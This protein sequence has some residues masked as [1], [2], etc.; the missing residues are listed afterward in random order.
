MTPERLEEK[1]A[2]WYQGGVYKRSVTESELDELIVAM[3]E[4]WADNRDLS[5]G[6]DGMIADREYFEK[7]AEKAE[8][9]AEH[10]NTKWK[11]SEAEVERHF[12]QIQDLCNT[13]L[14]LRERAEQAEAELSEVDEGI[15]D[16]TGSDT[17]AEDFGT[18][19]H[20]I[21]LIGQSYDEQN[22][23]AEKAEAA[24]EHWNTKWKEAEADRDRWM[25]QFDEAEHR[26][27]AYME[28]RD[29]L[30]AKL[31]EY[32]AFNEPLRRTYN[33]NTAEEA[34]P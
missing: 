22:A 16:A 7:I 21:E 19:R 8:A 9:A 14:I 33:E 27:L 12:R 28:E 18:R 17:I 3:E 1:M 10:W 13:G 5:E 30:A 11:E 15:K 2:M 23:R 25:G 24:A 20:A 31:K 6:I 26:G 29:K 4:A 32:E 34:T